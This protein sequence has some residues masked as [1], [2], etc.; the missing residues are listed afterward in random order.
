MT[1]R[2]ALETIARLIRAA[3]VPD[4]YAS[5]T[6]CLIVTGLVSPDG[7]INEPVWEELGLT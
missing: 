6:R 4:A 5:I 2:A 1:T 7:E 3:Q